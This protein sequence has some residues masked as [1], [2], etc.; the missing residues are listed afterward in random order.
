MDLK[1]SQVRKLE[2]MSVIWIN[3]VIDRTG[4]DESETEQIIDYTVCGPA[5]AEPGRI[6]LV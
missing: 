2:L 1:G 5:A 3:I 6:T 4:A